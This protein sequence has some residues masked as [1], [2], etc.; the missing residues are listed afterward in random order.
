ML[1]VFQTKQFQISDTS[2]SNVVKSIEK[3][4]K[5][6]IGTRNV[7]TILVISTGVGARSPLVP[8]DLWY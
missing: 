3:Y 1:V 4:I 7:A 6:Y 2:C 5:R 8:N